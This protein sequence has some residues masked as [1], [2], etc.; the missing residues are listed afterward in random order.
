M[1]ALCEGSRFT[2]V[3]GVQ[4]PVPPAFCSLVI[5]DQSQTLCSCLV[6]SHLSFLM[7]LA[8]FVCPP[9][10]FLHANTLP[11]LTVHLSASLCTSLCLQGTPQISMTTGKTAHLLPSLISLSIFLSYIISSGVISLHSP[12]DPPFF[13]CPFIAL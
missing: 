11:H 2:W 7:L 3:G 6:Q 10:P 12:N 1:F 8:W 9:P 13:Y 5:S 4:T